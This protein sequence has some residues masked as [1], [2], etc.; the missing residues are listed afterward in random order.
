MF[1]TLLEEFEDDATRTVEDDEAPFD[2]PV[3]DEL[4]EDDEADAAAPTRDQAEEDEDELLA[5]LDDN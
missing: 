2:Q 1:D 5:P 3:D 4:D